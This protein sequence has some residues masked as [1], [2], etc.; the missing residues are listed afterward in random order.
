[1]PTSMTSDVGYVWIWLPGQRTP[2]AAGVLR[3]QGRNSRE[4][5][6]AY[7]T[8]YL[9]RG[10]AISLYE[11]E[12]PL[13]SGWQAPPLGMEMA[14]CIRDAGPDYW[15]QMIILRD[16]HRRGEVES[17]EWA[18]LEELVWLRNSSSNK[19]GALDV[20]DSPHQYTARTGGGSLDELHHA[21]E[22]LQ[23]DQQLS[24]DLERALLQG[25]AVG[26]G[27][28]K[29]V[30]T[31]GDGSEWL[32]KFSYRGQKGPA[33][34]FEAAAVY[35]ADQCGIDVPEAHVVESLGKR[36]LVARRFDRPA[37]GTRRM[38]V[39]GRTLAGAADADIPA[40]SYPQ[41]MEPVRDRST[42]PEEVGSEMFDRIVFNIAISN[43]DDH[44]LNH[45]AFWDGH[46]LELT[47]A[48]DLDPKPRTGW[49]RTQM[50]GI[51]WD[52]DPTS[53]FTNCLNNA[54][55]YGLST[56]DAAERIAHIVAT[57][58]DTF[59]DAADFAQLTGDQRLQL[60]EGYLVPPHAF[61]GYGPRPTRP[62]TAEP[63]TY[64]QGGHPPISGS[65]PG[66]P[67]PSLD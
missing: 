33:V 12:L 9:N 32:A 54:A 28:P 63:S 10:D 56:Q 7:A 53:T 3:P 66:P 11:P 39:T 64:I 52:G 18:E 26:G 46:H 5:D 47:P 48:Y 25:T 23:E 50:L 15:G 30:L 42:R 43:Y 62:H 61:E 60:W 14:G 49:Q 2:V 21:A 58:R 65:E 37:D 41:I 57:I 8:S 17:T 55:T 20:Q 35:M 22:L 40:L 24:Q 59:D 1:M 36:V 38:V 29:A 19:T 51:G 27:F 34:Q 13:I 67:G 31:S 16:L 45:A 6:F 44:A 4:Y